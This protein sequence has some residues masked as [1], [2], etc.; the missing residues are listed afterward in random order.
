MLKPFFLNWQSEQ[1]QSKNPPSPG[2]GL[3]KMIKKMN[4]QHI[5]FG[6]RKKKKVV[7][8]YVANEAIPTSH[9]TSECECWEGD[10]LMYK[11]EHLN[12]EGIGFKWFLC[13]DWVGQTVADL[14]CRLNPQSPCWVYRKWS[15]KMRCWRSELTDWLES[16]QRRRWVKQATWWSPEVLLWHQTSVNNSASWHQLIKSSLGRL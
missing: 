2:M 10:L 16:V 1:N 14:P 13:V 15:D 7:Y 8:Y 5:S 6:L 11:R 4:S 9:C 3:S 12:G